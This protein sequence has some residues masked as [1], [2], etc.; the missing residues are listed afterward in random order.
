MA[1]N[2]EANIGRLLDTLLK[3]TPGGFII[4]EII[5]VS[6]GSTDGTETIVR[7]YAERDPKVIPLIQKKREGKASAV[8]L[9]LA[10]AAGDLL[11]LESA[12][13]VPATG[14]IEKLLQFFNDPRVGMV[15]ARP[16]PVN[17]GKNLVAF[18]VRKMWRLHHLISLEK[19]KVGEMVAFR[20]I[21]EKIPVE[22][23]VDEAC[24][25]AII[26]KK[27]FRICYAPDAVVY[28]RGPGTVKEFLRQR[29]RIAAGH[30]HLALTSGYRVSTTNPLR[31]MKFLFRDMAWS[32]REIMYTISTVLLEMAGRFLGLYDFYVRK[33]NPYVWDVSDSTKRL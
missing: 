23:A 13:T 3:E 15:G 32:V 22:T 33:K 29:R 20:P 1:Y 12:D 14:A 16:V 28:N 24:I 19:P 30:R 7:E 18:A 10:R 4:R 31:I 11:I 2:E 27:G 17:T 5:I 6:S 21:V 8:N 9:F 26:K 25:E